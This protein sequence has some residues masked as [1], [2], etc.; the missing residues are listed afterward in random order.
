MSSDKSSLF[1]TF[2]LFNTLKIM[3]LAVFSSTE[4]ESLKIKVKNKEVLPASV[5]SWNKNHF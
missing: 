5:R 4:H 1:K 3:F 2:D